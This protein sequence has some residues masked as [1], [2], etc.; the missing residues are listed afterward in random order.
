MAE[1]S[2][3]EP[4]DPAEVRFLQFKKQVVDI[5]HNVN[6]LITTLRNKLEIFGEDGGSN[7]EEKS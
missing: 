4:Q 6:L 5:N 3:N 7:V 2:I 1:E